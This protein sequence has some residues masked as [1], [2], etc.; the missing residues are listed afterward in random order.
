MRKVKII[1]GGYGVRINGKNKLCLSG[2]MIE[3]ENAE[4][5]RLV[6][7]G[8]GVYD[9]KA[10]ATAPA[11]ESIKQTQE[12]MSEKEVLSLEERSIKYSVKMKADELRE[13]AKKCGITY[14]VGTTKEE[15]VEALDEYFSNDNPPQLTVSDPI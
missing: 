6:S 8:V 2:T 15:M 9:N 12:S 7:L 4:A 10:V 11:E 13:I 14:K 3:V 1:S 5:E